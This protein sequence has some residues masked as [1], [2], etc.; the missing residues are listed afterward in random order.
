MASPAGFEP[1]LRRLEDM[2]K[3]GAFPPGS[4]DRS[5]FIAALTIVR[6]SLINPAIRNERDHEVRLYMASKVLS[7]PKAPE[8]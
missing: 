2:E 1:T 8:H 3:R 5:F 7:K 6:A 4:P